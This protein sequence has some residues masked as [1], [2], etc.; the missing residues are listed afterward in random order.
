MNWR[1]TPIHVIDFEGNREYGIV[2]Y[3]VVTLLNGSVQDTHTRLCR[4]KKEINY[5][6][7]KI[8]GIRYEETQQFESFHEDWDF[9]NSLRK[10]GPFAAHFAS[11]ENNLIKSVWPFPSFAPDF[12]NSENEIA[13]WG[14]W[15]DSCRI[16]EILFPDLDS[17]KL[18]K[19]IDTFGLQNQLSEF[20]ER[21]C[22]PKRSKYHCAL[23]D[24]LASAVLLLNIENVMEIEKLTVHWL[25]IN[26]SSNPAI[27]DQRQLFD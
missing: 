18:Q 21:F 20:A 7:T 11:V 1:N 12:L 5:A 14:P 8:H 25:L 19:L 13:T 16:Y 26:S 9:F 27:T 23:Y 22:P 6:D 2:E 10:Q 15:I 24:A 3:G 4:A 17:H